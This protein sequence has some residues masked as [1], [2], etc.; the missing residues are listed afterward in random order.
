MIKEF[1]VDL[2]VVLRALEDVVAPALANAEKH[3]IEQLMLATAT[4]AFVKKRLPEARRFWRMDL[5]GWIDLAVETGDIAGATAVL[6]AAVDAGEHA[7]RDP[8]ADLADFQSASR[9]LRDEITALSHAA[10]GQ[11]WQARL[12]AVI[13]EK[14]GAL[15]DQTRLWCAPMGFEL[16][17]QLLP[18]AAW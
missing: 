11:P 2:Q 7:L 17:P 13:L 15:L 4:I 6:S 9:R 3:V 5:R 10:V 12:E 16:Q 8:A 14:C 1:D 18:D